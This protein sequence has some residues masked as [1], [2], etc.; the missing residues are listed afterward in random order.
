MSRFC[1]ILLSSILWLACQENTGLA[2]EESVGGKE[3]NQTQAA[4]ID[5]GEFAATTAFGFRLFNELTLEYPGQNTFVSPPSVA[6]ALAMTYN[7]AE[8]ATAA[9][10]KQALSLEDFDRDQINAM[11]TDLM[12]LLEEPDSAVEL[13]IANSL[14]ARKGMPFKED[15]LQ[16]NEK[17]YRAKVS[18]LDFNSSQ[19]ADI[20]NHWV[21]DQTRGKIDGIVTPP[22]D[23]TTILFLINAIYFKGA[24]TDEFDDALTEDQEFHLLDGSTKQHPRMHQS[25]DYRYLHTEQFQ[26]VSL[27]YGNERLSMYVFLP[28]SD[29]SLREFQGTLTAT[30]WSRWMSEF[31]MMEGDIGLPRFRLEFETSLND[32]LTALGM[33][34][35]F[36]SD[37]ADFSAMFPVSA[38]ANVYISNV[39]HKTFVEVNEQG[40]EAAAVTSVEVRLAEAAP[41]PPQRFTM[42]V[43]RP[44]FFAIRDD[45]T[46][47]VLFMGSI[48]EPQ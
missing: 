9:A 29:L 43:D 47:T 18:D 14:W 36:D 13:S 22:I 26:A 11:F 37:N 24:W 45:R 46:G 15:F 17:H 4:G 30:N 3:Q 23:P 1:V 19:A 16:R 12:A 6:I 21:D 41:D 20:I 2:S 39:K 8:Q 7:G 40:T 31:R 35:A 28:S 33:G 42:I 25:G 44:F 34:V 32:A 10:M 27:P 48:V 5:G 38:D